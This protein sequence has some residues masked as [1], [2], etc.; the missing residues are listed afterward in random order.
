MARHKKNIKTPYL[1][2]AQARRHVCEIVPRITTRA[3]YWRWHDKN[4]PSFLPKRPDKVWD[5]FSWNDFLN[6]TNSFQKTIDRRKGVVRKYRDYWPAVRYVQSLAKTCN[7]RTKEDWMLYCK[8]HELPID[9][10]KRPWQVYDDFSM[11]VWLGKHVRDHIDSA[12]EV[13]RIIALHHAAGMPAN[14]I[15]VKV[16]VDG[17]IGVDD[18]GILG[19]LYRAYIEDDGNVLRTVRQKVA[20]HGHERD[21]YWII[22]NMNA[23]LWDLMELPLFKN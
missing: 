7:L 3:Q 6:T 2:Y 10:P 5:S 14:C 15:I 16:W 17:V 12:K 4:K 20:H 22:P 9:I 11:K 18:S 13:K 23:L 8:E 1:T 21:G 19:G